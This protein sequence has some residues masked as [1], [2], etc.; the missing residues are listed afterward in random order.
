MQ[1]VAVMEFDKDRRVFQFL[2]SI[3]IASIPT[4]GDKVC[5]DLENGIGYIFTVYD[6]HY[7][8]GGLTDVNV[9]RLSTITEYHANRYPDIS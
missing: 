1:Q 4:K 5:I 2:K 3:E 7:G 8:D 6:V 9:I